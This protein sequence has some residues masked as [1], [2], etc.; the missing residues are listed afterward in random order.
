[1]AKS[2]PDPVLSQRGRRNVLVRH[3]GADDPRTVEAERDLKAAGLE[4]HIREIIDTAPPITEE[5][6]SR[7]A[8]L[9]R[10]PSSDT[11]A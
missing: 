10:G 5:Q 7:L 4:Q 9:L 3:Y 8:L 6:R 1:V 2:T 11:A